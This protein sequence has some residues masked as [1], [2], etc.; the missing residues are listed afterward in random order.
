MRDRHISPRSYHSPAGMWCSAVVGMD[1]GTRHAR[2]GLCMYGLA[3]TLTDLRLEDGQRAA[4]GELSQ[5]EG[6]RRVE[7]VQDVRLA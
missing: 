3:A 6:L 7:V 2:C 1:H 4:G 5:V